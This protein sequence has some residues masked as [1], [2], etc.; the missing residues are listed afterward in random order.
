MHS[1]A[2]RFKGRGVEYEDLYQAGC[3]GLIKA[4]DGF[5]PERGFAF[6]TYAVPV[7]LG[8]IKRL[9]RDGGAIKISRGLKETSLK[10][11]RE[12]ERLTALTGCEPTIAQLAQSLELT[13]EQVAEA[14]S[15]FTPVLSL[16][17]SDDGEGTIDVPVVG[18]EERATDMLSLRDVVGKLPQ[19][20]RQII[21]L[22]YFCEVSQAKV[23]KMLSMTQVQ[24]SRREKKI[25]S[26]LK[27]L[28]DA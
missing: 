11:A 16:T 18:E 5:D 8:E 9:F 20:D 23:G 17:A 25:L 13:S 24:V 26:S 4:V 3:M 7:I 15:I 21:V 6:S 28:L 27:K 10:V 2:G 12:R 19:V 14:V 1:L 22:R